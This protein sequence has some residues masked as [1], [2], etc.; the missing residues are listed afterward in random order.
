MSVLPPL[1]PKYT[2]PVSKEPCREA[3]TNTRRYRQ[4]VAWFGGQL[5]EYYDQNYHTAKDNVTNLH[6]GAF[7]TTGK[8]IA[9]AVAVYGTSWEGFPSRN[10][11]LAARSRIPGIFP[12]K[13]AHNSR[14]KKSARRSKQR[15]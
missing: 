6:L 7:E 5:G 14:S 2:L 11:T 12:P 1:P 8:G 13:T 4:E 3:A 10:S 15:V 9:H